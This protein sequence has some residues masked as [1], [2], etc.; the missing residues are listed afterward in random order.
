MPVVAVETLGLGKCC[1]FLHLHASEDLT[2][3]LLQILLLRNQFREKSEVA[4]RKRESRGTTKTAT[5]TDEATAQKQCFNN[6]ER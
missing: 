1:I 5:S 6:G 3:C 4:G 2:G